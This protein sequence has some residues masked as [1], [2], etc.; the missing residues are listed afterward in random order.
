VCKNW[1]EEA[2]RIAGERPAATA[3][4]LQNQE[5]IEECLAREEKEERDADRAYWRPLRE[6]LEKLR[7]EARRL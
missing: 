3:G 4:L 7:M 2:Q 1:P 6:E 5:Q